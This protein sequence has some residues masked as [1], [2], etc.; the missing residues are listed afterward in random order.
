MSLRP[1]TRETLDGYWADWL[2]CEPA[3]LSG[4]GV[5]VVASR[6]PSERRVRCLFRGDATVAVAPE[7]GVEAVRARADALADV[8]GR[9]P[10]GLRSALALDGGRVTLGPQF[11]GYLDEATLAGQRAGDGEFETRPLERRDARALSRLR[12][13]CPH[14]EWAERVGGFDVDGHEVIHGRFAD[15]RLVAVAAAGADDAVAGIGV[16]THPDHRGRGHGRT[17]VASVSREL[18]ARGL[19][20]EYR[21]H[22]T[23]TGSLALARG[24]GFERYGTYVA[25]D[26]GRTVGTDGE[27]ETGTPYTTI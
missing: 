17:V 21:A 22:E 2:G 18:L 10:A 12:V 20:P 19:V 13:A 1:E 15:G 9:D 8:D 25:L 4:S 6:W 14:E 11:V 3:A 5:T 27:G 26:P 24:V 23:W 16:V 7:T